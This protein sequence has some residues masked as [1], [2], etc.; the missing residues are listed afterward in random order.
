MSQ[1]SHLKSKSSV[2]LKDGLP[3]VQSYKFFQ[4][5][6]FQNILELKNKNNTMI[7]ILHAAED[8]AW[9]HQNVWEPV[10]GIQ[11]LSF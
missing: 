2:S 1:S 8:M 5:I 4:Y 10:C 11:F 9:I 3:P 6:L 7:Y